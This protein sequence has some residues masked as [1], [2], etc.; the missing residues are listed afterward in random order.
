MCCPCSRDRLARLGNAGVLALL[1]VVSVLEPPLAS[2]IPRPPSPRPP[3]RS[4]PLRALAGFGPDAEILAHTLPRLLAQVSGY[5]AGA[6]TATGLLGTYQSPGQPQLPSVPNYSDADRDR[7]LGNSDYHQTPANP[8]APD[9]LSQDAGA[10]AQTDPTM[11]TIQGH[12]LNPN[13]SW[14]MTQSSQLLRDL[15]SRVPPDVTITANSCGLY[16]VCSRPTTSTTQ[17]CEVTQSYEEATCRRY[18][19]SAPQCQTLTSSGSGSLLD[20]SMFFVRLVA[21]SDGSYTLVGVDTGETWLHHKNVDDGPTGYNSPCLSWQWVDTG[22][23]GDGGGRCGSWTPTWDPQCI[24]DRYVSDWH[25]LAHLPASSSPPTIDIATAGNG[26]TPE[27]TLLTLTPY[28]RDNFPSAVNT[29]PSDPLYDQPV[30]WCGAD[31]AQL[32]TYGFTATAQDCHPVTE[33]HD[34]CVP[35]E[36]P[37]WILTS[38]TYSPPAADNP[39]DYA[40]VIQTYGKLTA[41]SDTCTPWEQAGCTQINQTCTTDPCTTAVRTYSCSEPGCAQYDQ[42]VLCSACVPDP[43][44]PPRCTSTET[45]IN[46]DFGLATAMMQG[47]VEISHDHD[48]GPGPEVSAFPGF[49]QG[50]KRNPLVNCCNQGAAA[51]TASDIQTSL[52]AL[53]DAMS[54]YRAANFTYEVA[55][56]TY[57][58]MTYSATSFSTAFTSAVGAEFSEMAAGFLSLSWT[59]VLAVVMVAVQVLLTI[60]M[61]C[62]QASTETAIKKDMHLCHD[63]GSY[64]STTAL[65]FCWGHT[66][67]YCC[68]STLLSRII[69]EGARAQLGIGWGDPQTPDCR[70]LTV[71]ELQA[72]NWQA[73]DWSEYVA[74]VNRRI[75]VP[76]SADVAAEGSHVLTNTDFGGQASAT[77]QQY[78]SLGSRVSADITVPGSAL[79]GSAPPAG[80]LALTI[81]GSG[82]VSLSPGGQGCGT[83]TC[84][85]SLPTQEALSA[86]AAPSAGYTFSGWSGLCTGSGPCTVM[87]SP[88]APSAQ[89]T[90]TFTRSGAPLLVTVNGSGSVSSAP[91]GLT[92]SAG[93]CSGTFSA[94][95]TVTLSATPGAAA[96]FNG[97]TGACSGTGACSITLATR[98]AVQSVTA[99]FVTLP[100]ITSFSPTSL[101]L[102]KAGTSISWTVGVTGG[103]SPIEYQF[104]RSDN[105][106]AVIVQDWSPTA[107]YTWTPMAAD[108]GTHQLQVAV[109]NAGSSSP[110][111]DHAITDPFEVGP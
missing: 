79:P 51:Q 92:C 38:Q 78:G 107:A 27:E 54:A 98:D 46:H 89:L 17:T 65:F 6:A 56:M 72:V 105:G 111:D 58:T 1:L 69:Q 96:R 82:T 106:N 110:G 109:R 25:V 36:Q 31:G 2:A 21:E 93:Q 8:N 52:T 95:E 33:Y 30:A 23:C 102:V 42:L 32:M 4:A 40:D 35:Y 16:Q 3:D 97:W 101:G 24:A 37:P 11:A 86:T 73:I 60:L 70:G 88:T 47:A 14:T 12:V 99:E 100:Q 77:I 41:V 13:G 34:D 91:A 20:D 44:G 39:T 26:C 104:I 28:A 75:H 83:Q 64:C 53:Q 49:A 43:P 50:C 94:G 90:A 18:Y 68:F 81:V 103:V 67:G 55:N 80:S 62:D 19:R 9:P 10:A 15:D 7:L 48:T 84:L 74:D 57:A 63:V 59:G 85:L 61:S 29:T 66:E 76:T 5:D 45:P 87:L 71:E 108:L 22:S